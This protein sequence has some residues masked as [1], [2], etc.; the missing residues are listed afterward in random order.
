MAKISIRKIGRLAGS[1]RF[2]SV[3]NARRHSQ[4]AIVETIKVPIRRRRK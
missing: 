2:T 3:K 4:T 1:G